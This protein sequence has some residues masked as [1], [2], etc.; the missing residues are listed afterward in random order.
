MAFVLLAMVGLFAGVLGGMLG[1]GGSVI[2]IPAM[3]WLLGVHKDHVDQ[4]HQYQAASM[5]V[6]FLVA[7]P[8]MVAH[9]R[10]K[11]VWLKVVAYMTPAGAA[12][13]ALGA[14]LSLAAFSGEQ[15]RYLRWGLGVVFVLVAIDSV[16]KTIWPT[17]AE[18]D[19]RPQ[20][21]ARSGWLKG[22]IGGIVGMFSG[23]TGLGGGVI[24]VPANHYFL[25]MPLRISIANSSALIVPVACV[26]A[27]FKNAL[28]DGD[29]SVSRSL[30]LAGCLG[31][32]AILGGYI[33]G[34]LT[35]RVPRRGLR[36]AFAVL[37]IVSSIKAF[38]GVSVAVKALLP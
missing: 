23:M 29:G 20:V 28:L 17:S 37:L 27:I 7:V 34:H 32:T 14:W 3:F 9:A 36:V 2:M 22:G 11:A 12:G 19:D 18:G 10:N 15:T 13:A 30:L 26:G 6:N 1:I 33:G 38:E 4:T 5:I 8:S 16:R 21:E 31:P 35:H 24:G 25:R